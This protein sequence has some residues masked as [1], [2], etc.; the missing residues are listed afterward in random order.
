MKKISVTISLSTAKHLS[1]ADG[2]ISVSFDETGRV[3]ESTHALIGLPPD[4]LRELLAATYGGQEAQSITAELAYLPARIRLLAMFPKQALI[5]ALALLEQQQG[6]DEALPCNRNTCLPDLMPVLQALIAAKSNSPAYFERPFLCREKMLI[7]AMAMAGV[8]PE[9]Y[10]QTPPSLRERY[11]NLIQVGLLKEALLS[12]DYASFCE[13]SGTALNKAELEAYMQAD[14][15]FIMYMLHTEVFGGHTFVSPWSLNMMSAHLR[16][17][18]KIAAS[19]SAALAFLYLNA[20]NIQMRKNIIALIME[21]TIM[22]SISHE[23]LFCN[24][25]INFI[26]RMNENEK[27]EDFIVPSSNLLAPMIIRNLGS[28]PDNP[29]DNA[30]NLQQYAIDE[31]RKTAAKAIVQL[32][33]PAMIKELA[34]AALYECEEDLQEAFLNCLSQTKSSDAIKTLLKASYLTLEA[35]LHVFDNYARPPYKIRI[36][37]S[38]AVREAGKLIL[39]KPEIVEAE[40]KLLFS[41]THYAQR[42]LAKSVFANPTDTI[43]FVEAYK[44]KIEEQ[45]NKAPKYRQIYK[46]VF[47]GIN[48]VITQIQYTLEVKSARQPWEKST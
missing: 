26:L 33:N 2:Q 48:T 11:M 17:G 44:L 16:N 45:A 38:F 37:A 3:I 1:L 43:L 23:R 5:T 39:A 15:M 36:R 12:Y 20:P 32:G 14:L 30:A 4:I 9:D 47:R 41:N 7:R 10:G 24:F 35:F 40:H 19:F 34:K 46:S 6:S 28:I 31:I 21:N 29:K 22:P 25:L 18:S 13:N 42:R 27:E 8:P